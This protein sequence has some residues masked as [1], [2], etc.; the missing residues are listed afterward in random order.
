MGS[1]V[2]SGNGNYVVQIWPQA[3]KE[4]VSM[5]LETVKAFKISPEA[6]LAPGSEKIIMV[7]PLPKLRHPPVVR[8]PLLREWIHL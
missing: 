2:Y 1:R 7:V 3:E 6:K 8:A 5:N 4:R